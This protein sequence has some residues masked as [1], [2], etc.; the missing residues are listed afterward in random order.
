MEAATSAHA[1]RPGITGRRSNGETYYFHPHR[2]GDLDPLGSLHCPSFP[3]LLR[4]A[5]MSPR[6]PAEWVANGL[7]LLIVISLVGLFIDYVFGGMP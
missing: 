7:A 2:P 3:H 5:T 1:K 6:K 4:Y